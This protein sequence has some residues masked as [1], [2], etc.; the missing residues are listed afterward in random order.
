METIIKLWCDNQGS[1]KNCRVDQRVHRI[2]KLSS[3]SH[4][5]IKIRRCLKMKC[6][7]LLTNKRSHRGGKGDKEQI[8]SELL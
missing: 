5:N 6:L 1:V 8:N 3:S 4:R 7:K 2:L